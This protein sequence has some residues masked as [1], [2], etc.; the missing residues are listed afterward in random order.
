MMM[1]S[2]NMPKSCGFVHDPFA[3]KFTDLN[4]KMHMKMAVNYTCD[5]MVDFVHMMHPHHTS[6]VN[7]CDILMETEG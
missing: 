3:S 6:A 1:N 7:M 5:H 4:N 2:M